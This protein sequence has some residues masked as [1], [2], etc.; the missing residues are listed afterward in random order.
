[1][2]NNKARISK[3][4]GSQDWDFI[5]KQKGAIQHRIAAERESIR[6][7]EDLTEYISRRAN[8][9]QLSVVRPVKIATDP[10]QVLDDLFHRLVEEVK[11]PSKPR[12]RRID[13]QLR[14]LFNEKGI[15]PLLQRSVAVDVPELRLSVH[16][17]YAYKNGRFNL[18]EPVQFERLSASTVF[19]KASKEAVE[20]Q[21]VYEHKHPEYGPMSMIVVGKFGSNQKDDVRTVRTILEKHSVDL[22][23][24]DNL[25]P[26]VADIRQSAGEHRQI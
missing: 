23:T 16:A 6:S 3:L 22:Y 12:E 7:I 9:I 15:T 18:I 8:A 17:P 14:T 21:F 5:E 11:H 26:L 20:G 4:F 10:W 24:F 19:A 1:M 13:L 2:D 25:D